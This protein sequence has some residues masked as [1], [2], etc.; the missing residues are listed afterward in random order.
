LGTEKVVSAQRYAL[1]VKSVNNFP[2]QHCLI[3]FQVS[4]E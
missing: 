2:Q 4:V 1:V 3:A